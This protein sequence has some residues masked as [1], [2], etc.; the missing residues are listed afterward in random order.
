MCEG[1]G[2]GIWSCFPEAHSVGASSPSLFS[3]RC[4]H[5]GSLRKG[6]QLITLCL[7]LQ[8]VTVVLAGTVSSCSPPLLKALPVLGET[9]AM[10]FCG[11]FE[12]ELE[13]LT[14]LTGWRGVQ[15]ALGQ[16]G[17]G[18]LIPG[19][20][21]GSSSSPWAPVILVLQRGLRC[22]GEMQH[23]APRDTLGTPHGPGLGVKCRGWSRSTAGPCLLWCDG[24]RHIVC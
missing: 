2:W 3:P 20:L 18:E 14:A 23:H 7:C 17:A 22:W 21:Q 6:Y 9:A 19:W 4:T 15:Q 10:P 5:L 11:P 8:N 24:H 1:A 16:H 12:T 13:L